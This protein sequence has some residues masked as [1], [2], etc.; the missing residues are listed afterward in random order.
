MLRIMTGFFVRLAER[1]MPDPLVIAI[2][3]TMICFAAA[4]AFT[5][6]GVTQTIDAWGEGYWS[7]LR[8]TAQMILILALGHVVAHTRPVNKVLIRMAGLVTSARVAYIALT[9]L[10]A[11]LALI[12]WGIGLIVPAVLSRIIAEDCR[13]RGIRIH[14]PLLVACAYSGSVVGM[15]GLSASIPLILNTPDHFLVEKIGLIGLEN[16]IFS[17][18]SIAIVITIMIFLPLVLSS[19]APADADIVE[20]PRS[21]DIAEEVATPTSGIQMTPSQK[22]ENARLITLAL[23]A[24]GAFYVIRYFA[25]GGSLNLNSL[26]MVFVVLGLLFADSSR[27]YIDLLCNAAK[28]AGP[29]LIQYP[30]YAG[31]MGMMAASGLAELF[32][33]GFVSISTA[34][35]LPIWT[36]FSAALLNIF[37]PSAGG[38]WAVQGPIMTEAAIQLGADIPR[39]A[40]AVTIGEVWTNSIQPLYA[41]PVLAIAGLHIRDIMAYTVLALM[42]N[43]VIYIIALTL[44]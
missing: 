23:G 36:F 1:W 20:M 19:A 15:Q 37:I 2:A 13:E 7:L 25:Y 10:A 16:T 32:V 6:F 34:E 21:A 22:L 18:W 35:T 17:P 11:C 31:L 24:F 27:H 14:F 28:I 40:M 12:S 29:F 30:L 9:L 43:G 41:V 26:N 3:L 5:P 42:V 38:Q 4:V 44:F 33:S 8:F 39:V